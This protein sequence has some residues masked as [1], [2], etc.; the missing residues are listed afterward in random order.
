[1]ALLFGGRRDGERDSSSRSSRS[2][3]LI[4]APGSG[5]R[6]RDGDDEGSG[7]Y[8]RVLRRR[9]LVRP[10]MRG[11]RR[12]STQTGLVSGGNGNVKPA[13]RRQT[14]PEPS[15]AMLAYDNEALERLEEEWQYRNANPPRRLAMM[16]R[17][18]RIAEQQGAFSPKAREKTYKE[19]PPAPQLRV[20]PAVAGVRQAQS[21][22][23]E[24]EVQVGQEVPPGARG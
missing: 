10:G 24:E 14:L 5:E 7:G 22:A 6:S 21:Q 20:Q 19:T 15:R 2:S 18:M 4:V 17:R 13:P 3:S 23:C 12:K 11:V 9:R 1:M 16:E 8:E